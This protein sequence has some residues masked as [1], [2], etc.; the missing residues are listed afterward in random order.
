MVW[1]LYETELPVL[2]VLCS[3]KIVGNGESARKQPRSGH[4]VS[5]STSGIVSLCRS[6]SSPRSLLLLA[7]SGRASCLVGPVVKLAPD[8]QGVRVPGAEGLLGHRQQRGELIPGSS[9]IPASPVQWASSRRVA[10]VSGCSAPRTRSRTGSSAAN[11][12]RPRPRPQP[13]SSKRGCYGHLVFLG[14]RHRTPVREPA[15]APRI[16]GPRPRPSPP[17]PVG[18]VVPGDQGVRMIG[19]RHPLAGRQRAANWSR[20]PAGSFPAPVERARSSRAPRLQPPPAGPA[21]QPPPGPAAQPLPRACRFQPLPQG[22]GPYWSS[23]KLAPDG[24]G[25]RVPGAEGLL[26]HRQQRGELIP[27]SSRIP[28]FPGPVGKLTPGG[29]GIGVLGTGHPLVDRQQRRGLVPG[30]GRR[31][32]Q[33]PPSSKRGCYGHLVFLGARHQ[34]PVRE[35]AAAPRTCTWP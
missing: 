33:P 8:G 27:G 19:A 7:N 12:S 15:A 30:G 16:R 13:P 6:R 9:R 10:R 29:Q 17:C 31:S 20:A 3:R 25:V 1:K 23:L 32:P 4:E 11:W 14:A 35:P 28:R 34:T 24:Q 5:I 22:S 2:S 21:A 26:G 18:K